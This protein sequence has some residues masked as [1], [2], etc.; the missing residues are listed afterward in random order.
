MAGLYVDVGI[1]HVKPESVDISDESD[2]SDSFVEETENCVHSEWKFF[3]LSAK[4]T[5][6]FH[7]VRR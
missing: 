5:L 2:W 7:F 3:L 1:V 4:D 6:L